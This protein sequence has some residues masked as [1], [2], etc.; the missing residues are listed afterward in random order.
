MSEFHV[1]LLVKNVST[2]TMFYQDLFGVVPE[3]ILENEYLEFPLAN[4]LII[5]IESL[6]LVQEDVG[7]I[8]NKLY[9]RLEVDDIEKLHTKCKQQNVVIVAEPKTKDYGKIEMYLRDP[10]GNLIQCFQK[11]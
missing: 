2:L 11:I 5:D 9:L 10:E 6:K 7:N 8:N 1:G 3:I 4:N